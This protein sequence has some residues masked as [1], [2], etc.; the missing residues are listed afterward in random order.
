MEWRTKIGRGISTKWP[1]GTEAE[2]NGNVA[3]IVKETPNSI[4]Y[5]ELG[6]AKKNGLPYGQVQNAAGNFISADSLSVSA[7]ATTAAKA[8]PSDFRASVTNPSGERAYPIS[9]FTWI[10][11]SENMVSPAK[12]AA[13]KDSLRWILNEGQ[14]YVDPAGFTK[15]PGSIVE[16]ELQA[17]ER[18]P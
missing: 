12:Q 8:M 14:A 2:G 18:I 4:A 16:Q 9:S 13:V 1:V 3:R 11:V 5:V 10:L 15:L 7:A 17:V 6:Y